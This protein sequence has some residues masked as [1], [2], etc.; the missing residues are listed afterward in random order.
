MPAPS[1]EQ[2][3]V[4]PL[5]AVVAGLLLAAG[6]LVFW[7]GFASTQS[8]RAQ[9]A[10]DAAALGGEK[11]LVR[12][13]QIPRRGP[14]GEYLPPTFYRDMV[15]NQAGAYAGANDSHLVGCDPIS[16]TASTIGWDVQVKVQGGAAMPHGSPDAGGQATASAR[17]SVDPLAQASP[18][19]ST[20]TTMTACEASLGAGSPFSPHEGR[21]GFF[22]AAGANYT[23][24]CEARL[25]GAL[26]K[27]A[28]D[29]H[30]RLT[31][32]SGY[33]R[34]GSASGG[35]SADPG[36]TAT[37]H[38]CGAAS[39]TRGLPAHLSV[40]V[41]ARYGLVRPFPGKPDELEL[42]G[43]GCG[44]QT[45][46]VDATGS[47][48][49]GLG[50]MNVHLVPLGG[51]PAGSLLTLAGGLG[52]SAL[53][54]S[55]VQVGCQIYKAWQSINAPQKVLFIGLLVASDESG[56]GQNIGP[57]RTDPSQS[58]GVFQQI[59]DDGWGTIAQEMDVQ[60]AAEMF[61]MGAHN[62]ATG[63]GAQGLMTYYASDP[64]APAWRLAQETQGS[65]AGAASGGA[66]NYG[67]ASNMAAAQSMLGQ[68]TGGACH[69]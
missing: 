14:N 23:F 30:L 52:P 64:G 32:A 15:C 9:T 38:A 54:E 49:V 34:G 44:Q 8:T 21:F 47:P 53:G 19:I 69:A 63:Q 22:P 35:G 31:G 28:V 4:L 16:S 67:S 58:I 1:G 18:E 10:A 12:E 65:G 61:F 11:E 37:A 57:N 60:S 68:V 6:M 7:L 55:A 62:P 45:T 27:L 42:S 5:V 59:S 2:G 50:N 41:L 48:P 29:L 24:G 3:Q 33:V 17:A 13:L 51:G 40:D 39:T 43:N 66:A 36:A 46:D 56:F 20:R 26:D 25:A